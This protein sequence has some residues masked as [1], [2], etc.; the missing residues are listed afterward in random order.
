MLAMPHVELEV[1]LHLTLKGF[2][3]FI[4]LLC[5]LRFC[6]IVESNFFFV[7]LSIGC[8]S[9]DTDVEKINNEYF[10]LEPDLAYLKDSVVDFTSLE[11]SDKK[12]TR[13]VY[14]VKGVL[15]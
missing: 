2:G 13:Q 12:K 8:Y 15:R 14:Q 9:F 7:F 10:D 1:T 3:K 5:S 4:S 6:C 11:K